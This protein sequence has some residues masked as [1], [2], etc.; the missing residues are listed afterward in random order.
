LPLGTLPPGAQDS[1]PGSIG[2]LFPAVTPSP[3]A[4]SPARPGFASHQTTAFIV[5]GRPSGRN[6]SGF[7]VL[8]IAFG[9]A[10][11]VTAAWLSLG[12][13]GSR[14]RAAL[15]AWRSGRG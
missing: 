5:G 8:A 7:I 3:A 1:P 2:H 15:D 9:A 10:I 6:V 4:A 11:A 13:P 12:R 14:P